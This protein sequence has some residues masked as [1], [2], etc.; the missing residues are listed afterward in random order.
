MRRNEVVHEV[1]KAREEQA[2]A[3][4]FDLKAQLADARRRQQQAG[5]KIASFSS[6]PPAP[7]REM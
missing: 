6:K 1:R 4:D 3:W 5:R 7:T 2:A